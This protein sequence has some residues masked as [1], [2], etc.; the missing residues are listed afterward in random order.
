MALLPG[1]IDYLVNPSSPDLTGFDPARDRLD[2]GDTSVHGL[3]LGKLPDGSAILVNPWQSSDYQRILGV[4]GEPILWSQ[5][6]VDNLGVVGN[7]HLR[8]DAG[9][10]LSWELGVGPGA[11]WPNEQRT[12]Y[13]RSHEW[14]VQERVEGFDPQTDKLN[15][16][17]LGTRERLS[18]VDTDEGLLISV[19]PSGQSILLVGVLGEELVGRNLEF[20]FDQIEEDNLEDVF[21]FPANA[22]S[23]VDRS[24]LLTPQAPA[25]QYTDGAQTRT[26]TDAL[27]EGVS[28]EPSMSDHASH[29]DHADHT[30]GNGMSAPVVSTDGLELSVSGTLY[31][32]GMSG[33]LT[34]TNAGG[35][36]VDG[37]SVSFTTPHRNVQSWSGGTEI[38]ALEDGLYRVTL[39]PAAWNGLIASG[40]SIALSFNAESDGLPTSGELTGDL[41]FAAM[42]G[43]AE[44][45]DEEHSERDHM[46]DVDHGEHP[47]DVHD[48]VVDESTTEMPPTE[49][50]GAGGTDGDGGHAGHGAY[51]AGGDG[52]PDPVVSTGGLE[53]AV[54]GNLYWGGMSGQLTLTN[55]GGS[56]V[57]GWSVS[58]T[59][60]HRNVQSW[61]GG[62]EIEALE[63]GLYRVTLT[64]AA[65]NGV[66]AAGQSIALSF[67]AESEGLP[68]SGELTDALFFASA[69]AVE[70]VLEDEP[71]DL[72]VQTESPEATDVIVDE[73][74]DPGEVDSSAQGDFGALDGSPSTDVDSP[75]AETNDAVSPSQ[76][77]KR[78]VGYFEEWG[79]YSRDF[80]V[81][82][83][84]VEDLTHVN[85]S[86]FDVR[87]NGELEVFDDW[88]ATQKRF[89]ADE[90]VSRTFSAQEWSELDSARIENYRNAS[91][92]SIVENADQSVTV[93]GQPVGWD[94]N[95]VLAGNLR[96]FQLLKA[97]N[98]ELELG[99]ALGGWTLSDEFS[100]AL[101]DAAGREQFTDNVIDTLERYT[102]F[103]TVDFD[104]EYPGG[105][106]LSSNAVSPDDGENFAL[107]LE[108]LRGKLDAL[109]V[110]SGRDYEISIATSAT[111]DKLAA[112]NLQ[113]V[114]P[115]VD[116]YNV[117]AYDFHGGWELSTG[118]QAA[119][120]GDP[121]GYDVVTA[122][123]TFK[124]S[125]VALNKVVLG[126]PAYTRAW[127][128]VITGDALGYGEVGRA[129]SAPGSFEAG[130]YDQKDL[131]TGIE[132]GDY[133]LA[134]DDDALAAYAYN[135]SAQVWSSIETPSTIAGKAAFVEAADLGGMMFWALSNDSADEQSLIAAASDLLRMGV[136]AESVVARSPEFDQ[137]FGGDGQFNLSD[138]TD[139]AA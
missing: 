7:E 53:L 76:S 79:I 135:A 20:H 60:P 119:M 71:A 9:G 138:F 74:A 108:L 98:P 24:E 55:T 31:W 35:S 25:G 52:M 67:N 116:F 104:W 85:Y 88:A 115:F 21:G 86:F 83:I 18:A 14:G 8:Q 1:G 75:G 37:W 23:L 56:D 125:G 127:G 139:L 105:G 72:S 73:S 87:A 136:S 46:G 66:I 63:G 107:T 59:T 42:P 77:D 69:P 3:I 16:L 114:D 126:A 112:L 133:Q 89:A 130:N 91:N 5:L 106:G 121:S 27:S 84:Q 110:R 111:A 43:A 93:S 10:A 19:E 131:I 99:L 12:V 29:D 57:E 54:S 132:S 6:S 40:Q 28:G 68:T 32:G 41:F 62:T 129:A 123:E 48:A 45:V 103:T 44:G 134:W 22:L 15:F 65:W 81:Q 64:P 96:Q 61:S 128:D 124:D 82:D 78:I 36:D 17:Y 11:E 47:E 100:L 70:G 120:T 38:E 109:E 118:H 30:G 122:V 101:D 58:F 39:T 50:E 90:Q 97:L 26:G 113:G 95:D 137:V 33:Q 80:L 92:F 4:D 49:E 34:L 94:Q 117:M 2:F 102:F 51:D 13:V